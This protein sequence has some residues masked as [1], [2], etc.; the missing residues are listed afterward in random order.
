MA[1]SNTRATLT[2]ATASAGGNEDI[3][4][5]GCRA[6][7]RCANVVLETAQASAAAVKNDLKI[8]LFTLEKPFLN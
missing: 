8:L 5:A 3:K 1:S 2:I 6:E 7:V 4:L